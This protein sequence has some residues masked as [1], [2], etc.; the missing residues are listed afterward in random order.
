MTFWVKKNFLAYF[1]Q[2]LSLI[3]SDVHTTASED[4]SSEYSSHSDSVSGQQ[5]DRKKN[6]N[7][8]NTFVID[9]HIESENETLS[10][11]GFTHVSGVTIECNN[12]QSVSGK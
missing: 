11:D 10:G 6:K 4:I 2:V 3:I 7:K 12:S 1:M 8:N 9:H 5:E